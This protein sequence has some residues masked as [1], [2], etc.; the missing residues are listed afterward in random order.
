MKYQVNIYRWLRDI[1]FI[2]KD[3]YGNYT[4][5]H[6]WNIEF[7]YPET[8]MKYQ[9]IRFISSNHDAGIVLKK[10][11]VLAVNV[12]IKKGEINFTPPVPSIK[13]KDFSS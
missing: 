7:I 11:I 5:R 4:Q 10:W 1:K 9:I 2:H 13:R 8:D 3:D 6:L 12:N